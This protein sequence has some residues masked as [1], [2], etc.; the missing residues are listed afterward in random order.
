MQL[1]LIKMQPYTL[2]PVTNTKYRRTP[3]SAGN[4]FKIYRDYVK[5]NAIYNVTFV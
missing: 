5:P 3:L 4:T 2:K 1:I